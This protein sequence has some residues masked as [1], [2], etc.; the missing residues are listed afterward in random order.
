MATLI[1]GKADLEAKDKVR[2]AEG[3]MRKGR[4]RGVLVGS[5]PLGEV[6]RRLRARMTRTGRRRERERVE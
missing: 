4:W 6:H 5:M 2:G 1:E 3:G